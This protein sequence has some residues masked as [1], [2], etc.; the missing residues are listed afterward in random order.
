MIKILRTPEYID[1]LPTDIVIF[2]AG[3]IQGSSN[4]HDV[5]IDKIKSIDINKNI[6]ICSPKR[7]NSNNFIYDEQVNWESYHLELASKQGIIVFWLAE[8]KYPVEGRSYAQT[9]RFE[10]GEWWTKGQYIKNFKILVGAEEGFNGLR[11]IIKKFKDKYDNF[12]LITSIDNL[13]EEIIKTI[14]GFK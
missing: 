1:I 10:L 11:Y 9:T 13:I 3:P 4:W 8:E 2:L 6:I 14:N 7:L 12:N 5:I